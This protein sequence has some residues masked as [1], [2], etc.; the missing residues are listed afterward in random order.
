VVFGKVLNVTAGGIDAHMKQVLVSMTALSSKL[1]LCLT[2]AIRNRYPGARVD[3]ECPFYQ[4]NIPEVY[5][6]WHFSQRF[7]DHTELRQY[8]A[9]VDKVLGLRKD[10]YFHARVNDATWDASAKLWTV[11]TLQGHT[12]RAKYLVSC[13]GLLHRTYTPNF[14]GLKDYKGD[15]YHSGAW[16]ESFDPKGKKIG[17][18]GAGAT[19]VQITQELGKTADSLTVFLRRPSYCLPMRNRPWTAEEQKAWKSF[20]PVLFEQGRNSMAGFP[21]GRQT[22]GVQDVTP[23]EREALFEDLWERGGFNYAL[24]NYNNVLMDKDAN[25]VG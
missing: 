2:P 11:K 6:D 22:K 19:A 17:L 21:T 13:T 14:P 7:S 18:I 5:R 4:L 3:S 9:H 12:A 16:N 8:M 10:T 23:E 24:C 15:I 20:Y 25:K 1:R